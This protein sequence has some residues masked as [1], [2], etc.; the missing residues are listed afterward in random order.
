M[1]ALS[2]MWAACLFIYMGTLA[3][4]LELLQV[5]ASTKPLSAATPSTLPAPY[6]IVEQLV[7]VDTHDGY[8]RFALASA[9]GS[10]TPLP[11]GF[12]PPD[13]DING[14]PIA[15]GALVQLECN[16]AEPSGLV[17]CNL[18][19]DGET[20]TCTCLG[21]S[22]VLSSYGS[23]SSIADCVGDLTWTVIELPITA[24]GWPAAANGGVAQNVKQRPLVMI[25]DYP[26]CDYR[27]SLDEDSLTKLYLGQNR[28][29]NGGVAQKYNQCSYGS[30]T[31][32]PNATRVVTITAPC[33]SAILSTCSWWAISE[34]ADA[35]AIAQLGLQAFSSFTHY[36]YVLPPD[37]QGV[38]GWTGLSVLPGRRTW[39]Q[40]NS[41]GIY[42]WATVMQEGLHNYGLWHAWRSGWELG[43]YSTVMGR[44]DAC[45]NAAELARLGWATAAVGGSAIDSSVLTPGARRQWILPATYRTGYNNYLRVMP[46]WLPAY[47]N[48][49]LRK[50]L[51]IALR[52]PKG[53]D[54][55]LTSSY[56][57][58]V[59][60]HE[61]NATM[62]DDIDTYIYSDRR[63][64]IIAL[65][66]PASRLII[67]GYKLVVQTGSLESNDTIQVSLCTFVYTDS[68][69]PAA[70]V[71]PSPSLR[72]P[73]SPPPPSPRTLSSP[74]PPSLQLPPSPSPPAP[75]PPPSPSPPSPR[76]PP[77]PPPPSPRP[78]PA[79]PPP[80]PQPP[81]S[82]LPPSPRPPP[83]P[84]PPSPQPPPSPLPPSPQP[85]PSPLPPSPRPPPSP[86]PPSPR[87]PPSPLP[88]S[89]RPPPSPPPPSP[90]P[91]PSPSPL[92]PRPLSALSP[93]FPQPPPPPSPPSPRPPPSPS[94]P[95]PRPPPS[96]LPPSPRPPPSPSPPSPQQPPSP[97]PPSP[98]RLP[99]G[100][101][102]ITKAPGKP[103]R[104]PPS[105]PSPRDQPTK[106]IRLVFVGQLVF[107]D[108]HG[109]YARFALVT[110]NDIIPLGFSS[111]D[112]D[113]NGIPIAVGAIVQLECAA[114]PPG[115]CS[116]CPYGE[117]S[118]CSCFGTYDTMS[119]MNC[120]G[121]ISWTVYGSVVVNAD[122]I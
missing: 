57:N 26:S 70:A 114:E 46:T 118:I 91:P 119:L 43:D 89:P 13:F 120:I 11:D 71:L 107:V 14:I 30:F 28:D 22:P 103:L 92:S 63:V 68:E 105:P 33:D 25:L 88:P 66:P 17:Y 5:K 45:P 81:P 74:S 23:L 15:V 38:C 9:E 115:F 55:G 96:P 83:S 18:C 24:A 61:V 122:V 8:G 47:S 37:L 95:S 108:T 65:V 101:N 98:I 106:M 97:S 53:G 36:T 87:P 117:S 27:P 77:S 85:P 35:A 62:E 34:G 94:P 54:V 2:Q 64:Q 121:D 58:R 80:S 104:Y 60:V 86:S 44:G 111:P 109:G 39:F 90:Q 82:P 10:L 42:R 50:N 31:F 79:P 72:P 7:F 49:R 4:G 73:P 93:P 99:D 100:T 6:A 102:G 1:D 40:S 110:D 41:Y 113:I 29:G 12:R 59:H 21:S 20:P 112:F 76:P 3:G 78:P 19:P 32:K 51:Y 56:A 116:L 52:V 67:Y 84:S 69:C 75:R 16:K 48:A